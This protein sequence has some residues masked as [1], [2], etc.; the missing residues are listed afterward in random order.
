MLA[1]SAAC[2]GIGFNGIDLSS[3]RAEGGWGI[4]K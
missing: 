4:S 2:L 3:L 1:E